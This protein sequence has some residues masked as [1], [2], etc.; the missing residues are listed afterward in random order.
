MSDRVQERIDDAVGRV[1]DHPGD[2]EVVR[3]RA[4]QRQRRQR[5]AGIAVALVFLVGVAVGLGGDRVPDIPVIGSDAT[6]P[7]VRLHWCAP[8]M[9]GDPDPTP[10]EA[11]AALEADPAVDNVRLIPADEVRDLVRREEDEGFDALPDDAFA[12]VVEV[13]LDTDEPLLDV[14][15]RFHELVP[16]AS[17]SPTSLEVASGRMRGS[18]GY[19]GLDPRAVTGERAAAVTFDDLRLDVWPVE[20][21]GICYEVDGMVSCHLNHLVVDGGS[22]GA[23]GRLEDGGVCAWGTTGVQVDEVTVAFEDGTNVNASLGSA[24]DVLLGQ[25][26]LACTDGDTYP[27]RIDAH[28]AQTDAWTRAD[29]GRSVLEEV[30]RDDP[31]ALARLVEHL[32]EELDEA[33]LRAAFGDGSSTSLRSAAE[34]L[35]GTIEAAGVPS[36]FDDLHVVASGVDTPDAGAIY[37]Y[38]VVEAIG[39]TDPPRCLD[40]R[41]N[42][43]DDG[44]GWWMSDRIWTRGS[45]PTP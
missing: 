8:S 32:H 36:G 27:E 14:V 43:V 4:R 19:P 30:V 45:C 2:I 11:V 31:D 16:T 9:C 17:I 15:W 33:A 40:V 18:D 13:R 28:G 41:L 44:E 42:V 3:A 39:A 21:G 24:P 1:P 5:G 38:A 20:H 25:A 37:V 10:E 35:G 12:P 6:D 34:T 22:Q 7:I 29:T 23:W 26:F